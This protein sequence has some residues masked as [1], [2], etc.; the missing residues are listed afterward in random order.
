ML[1]KNA[2][3]ISYFPGYY[4]T[5]TGDI[6]SGPK[7]RR[8]GY[9]KLKVL[10]SN[11]LGHV[12][13]CLYKNGQMFQRLVHRLVLETFI[14]GCPAGFICRHLDGNPKNN[15]LDNL[16]WGTYKENEADKIR[17][18]THPQGEKNPQAKLNTFQVRVIKRLLEFNTLQQKEIA[19]MFSV[20]LGTINNIKMKRNWTHI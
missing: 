5:P 18:G 19:K 3:N 20:C 4:I 15:T 10:I 11:K 14:G 2:K 12:K 13:I 17:H 8:R 7:K 1:P 6:W 16:C 9:R